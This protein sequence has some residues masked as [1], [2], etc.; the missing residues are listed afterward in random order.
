VDRLE[1]VEIVTADG[2]VRRASRTTEPELFWALRG[3]GGNFGVVT[4]FTFSLGQVGPQIT[5][6]LIAWPAAHAADVLDAFRA[7]ADA[8]PR[9]LTMAVIRRNAPPAPWLPEVAHGK[10]L[11]MVVAC[12]SGTAEQAREDLASLRGVG[13][14]L[15]DL[16]VEKEY[17]AQQTQLD[18]TQPTGMHYYWK[19]E[20]VPGISDGL[21]ETY[22]AQFV[23]QKAP[24]NQIV[25]F[26]V[27]GALNELAEDDGAVGNRD[28]A[29][30]CVVQS[31]GGPDAPHDENR[32]W[33]RSAWEAIRAYGT[34]G[35]YINFQTDD[36]PDAR[37]QGSY[38]SNFARLQAAKQQYDPMNV[39]RVNRN[40]R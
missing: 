19:S 2:N 20:F 11:I 37:T 14:P 17:A 5:G 39:F 28:A 30:A 21:L 1:E 15:A 16:I 8:A 33:V 40:I 32:A 12:H 29:F 6:G 7:T 13:E 10:P 23:D 34:G 24:A 38:R 27:A 35:N 4:E 9:E 26:H 36:E 22:N 25:L 3:G 31:M 18:A